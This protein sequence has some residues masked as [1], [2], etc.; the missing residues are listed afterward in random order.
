MSAFMGKC[1]SALAAELAALCR[2]GMKL[3][4]KQD[5]IALESEWCV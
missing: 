2:D 5:L 4:S 1:K 3:S